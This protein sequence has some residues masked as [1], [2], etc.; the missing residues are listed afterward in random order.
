[1]GLARRVPEMEVGR[2]LK[3]ARQMMTDPDDEVARV[4]RRAYVK[5]LELAGADL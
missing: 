3:L 5:L 4:A 2:G 1:M